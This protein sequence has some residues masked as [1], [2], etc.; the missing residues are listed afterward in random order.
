MKIVPVPPWQNI[1]SDPVQGNQITVNVPNFIPDQFALVVRYIPLEFTAD[2]V[3]KE[4]KR[5]A[6]TAN[7][8][9]AI[10]YPYQRSTND[11][12]FTFADQKEYN[13]LLRLGHIEV[14]NR[15]RTVT[16]YRSANKLTY[17][18]KCWILSHTQKMPICSPEMQNMSTRLQ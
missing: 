3:A 6:S 18:T 4:V 17:C 10:F 16:P 7:N 15:M 1:F 5:S 14:G 8:F 2:Q 12:R 13:G 9:R 11:F